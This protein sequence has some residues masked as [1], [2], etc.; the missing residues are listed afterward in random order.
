MD[1]YSSCRCV[2]CNAVYGYFPR[3]GILPGSGIKHSHKIMR[4]L[5]GLRVSGDLF[6]LP[7]CYETF[8]IGI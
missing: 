5:Q 1:V 8:I 4:F 2:C 6:C 3:I 7:F